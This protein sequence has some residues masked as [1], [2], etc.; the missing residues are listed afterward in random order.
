MSY[1][2]YTMKKISLLV[3]VLF[4]IPAPGH[5]SLATAVEEHYK[6]LQSWRADFIQTTFIEILNDNIEKKGTIAVLRPDK[7]HIEYQNPKK[8]YVSDGK[9]LWI[10]KYDV[11]AWEFNQPKKIISEE[12]LSFLSGLKNLSTLFD[13]IENPDEPE[14]SL[15]IK[16]HQLK[17]ISLVPKDKNSAVLKITL[18][19]DAHNQVK[20]AVLFNVSGNVSHYE[21]RDISPNARLD[22]QLF[23]LPD[24]KNRKI[25]KK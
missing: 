22:T 10:Y 3:L 17:K 24:K 5:A 7:I 23:T 20:E 16:N 6:T 18:G 19:V 25:I 4:F 8:V 9:K 12:A 14:G 2:A 21:F 15:K 1:Q 13:V 11:T